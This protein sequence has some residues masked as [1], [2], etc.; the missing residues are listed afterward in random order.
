MR[1]FSGSWTSSP[2]PA[3]GMDNTMRIAY[4]APEIPA[5]SSTFVYHEILALRE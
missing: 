4:L 5:L 1:L 3:G 2:P